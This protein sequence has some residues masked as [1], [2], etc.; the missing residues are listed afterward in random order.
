LRTSRRRTVPA[1]PPPA[2]EA[3]PLDLAESAPRAEEWPTLPSLLAEVPL[4]ADAVGLRAEDPPDR[5]DDDPSLLG[6]LVK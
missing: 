5:A 6:R 2:D 3:E 4:L 1:P